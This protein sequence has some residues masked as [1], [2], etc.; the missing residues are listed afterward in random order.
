MDELSQLKRELAVLA[1]EVKMWME[2]TTEYRKSLCYKVDAIQE[3]LS[4]LPCE[5]GNARYSGLATQVKW[6]WG[7]L[8]SLVL[9]VVSKIWSV[10]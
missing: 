7:L 6:L 3:K 9:L 8:C 4:N 10:K 2:S 1:S 5:F